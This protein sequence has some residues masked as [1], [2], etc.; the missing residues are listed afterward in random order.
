MNNVTIVMYHYIRELKNS[1]YPYI[2]ALDLALFREQ[3]AYIEKHYNTVT[4]AE[5][6][7]AVKTGDKLPP[8]AALL[9][10]DDAYS[11]HFMTAFPI[12]DKAKIQ[13]CFFPPAKCITHNEILDVNKIHFILASVPNPQ[14]L[15]EFINAALK[16]Y[17]DQYELSTAQDY[18]SRIAK[19]TRYDPAEIIYIK[20]MLQR[21]LPEDLR[22][23]LTDEIFQKYVSSD[24]TAFSAELYMNV[25][26]ISH[27]QRNGMYVGSHGFDHYWLNSLSREKQEQEIDASLEFLELVGAP[28]DDWMMCYPYGGYNDDT[29]DILR[30]KECRLGLTTHVG[31]ADLDVHGPLVLP[32]LD[33]NDL[34]KDSS[35]APSQWTIDA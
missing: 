2:K 22:N 16:I 21:E 32:R 35:A 24:Q 15:I 1:R 30:D 13:G 19:P 23:I 4:A 27:M 25:D 17:A 31:I 26:Q 18:W 3:I 28:T 12:L 5:V 10:F 29:L 11:D 14:E 9:T 33:T 6:M 8:K 34:P 20:R 7:H